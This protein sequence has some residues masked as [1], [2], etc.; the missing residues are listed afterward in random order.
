MPKGR[1]LA[2][3]QVGYWRCVKAKAEGDQSGDMSGVVKIMR[4]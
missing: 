2:R 3:V 1:S 4:V